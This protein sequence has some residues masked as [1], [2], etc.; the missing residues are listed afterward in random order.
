MILPRPVSHSMSETTNSMLRIGLIAVLVLL[1]LPLLAMLAMALAGGTM[2]GWTTP[3]TMP[4]WMMTG[5]PDGTVGAGVLVVWAAMA[6]VPLLAVVLLGA[7]VW[8]ALG[9]TDGD[10]AVEELRRAYARGDLTDEEYES[11]RERLGG[12]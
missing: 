4:G 3:W 2:M 5:G 9:G 11:R 8:R 12:V 10:P 7:L 6:L 1:A